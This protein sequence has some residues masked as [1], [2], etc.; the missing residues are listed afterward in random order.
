MQI[1]GLRFA[2]IDEKNDGGQI[3][4]SNLGGN[5][6]L[7]ASSFSG[8]KFDW[9][10]RSG[11]DLIAGLLGGQ[12]AVAEQNWLVLSHQCGESVLGAGMSNERDSSC[13]IQ[14]VGLEENYE[15]VNKLEAYPNNL[16]NP[17]GRN[18]EI[19]LKNWLHPA[20]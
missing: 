2:S 17:A 10:T 3:A 19:Y 7:A 18:L 6:H 4:S 8:H 5:L 11:G 16:A 12:Q 20:L 14:S 13:H 9:Q 1:G 15:A